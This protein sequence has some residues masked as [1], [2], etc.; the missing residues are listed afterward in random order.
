MLQDGAFRNYINLN[1]VLFE[2]DS[3]LESIGEEAFHS[4]LIKRFTIPNKVHSI[5]KNAFSY[6]HILEYLGNS[7]NNDCYIYKDCD[8]LQIAS[9]PNV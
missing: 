3:N 9:F 6:C 8:H 5:D 2:E 1:I 7:F 4:T